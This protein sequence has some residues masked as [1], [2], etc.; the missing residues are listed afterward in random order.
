MM[1][2]VDENRSVVKT[3][4]RFMETYHYPQLEAL[5]GKQAY[6]TTAIGFTIA[7]KINSFGRL[8]EIVNP[9]NLVKF[10]MKDCDQKRI[11]ATGNVAT[12]INSKRQSMT[13]EAYKEALTVPHEDCLFYENE[14]VHEGLVGLIAGK[15]ASDYERPAFVMHHDVDNHLYKGSAR[16]VNGFNI[17]KFLKAHEDLFLRYGGHAMAGGFSVDEEHFEALREALYSDVADRTFSNEKAVIPIDFSDLSLDSV[18][19][20][21][22]LQPFGEGNE[23]PLFLLNNGQFETVRQLSNGK[24]LRFDHQLVSCRLSALYFNKGDEYNALKGGNITPVGTLSINDFRGYKSVNMII[25]DL[26]DPD[27]DTF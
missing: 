19:S 24:H 26:A 9:N 3:A 11:I 12:D 16:G 27:K 7:P 4:L 14:N 20:L 1:P 15:Y 22:D 13:N 18:A 21:E 25:R 2:L 6:T 8:P 23:Q 17:Y 5:V 10:F